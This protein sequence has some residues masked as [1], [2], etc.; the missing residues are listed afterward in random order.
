VKT[1]ELGE[2][3]LETCV[4]D[5]QDDQVVLTRGGKAVAL[6]IALDEEQEQLGSSERFWSLIAERRRQPTISRSE[7]E[8]R[9]DGAP[10]GGRD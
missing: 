6:L 7:L 1:I 9:L 2:S 10:P 4:D 5:A 3:S 8:K